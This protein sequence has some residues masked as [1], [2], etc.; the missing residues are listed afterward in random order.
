MRGV[1][2]L[3]RHG[4][5]EP[6]THG[7][8]LGRGDP[9][10]TPRGRSQAAALASSLPRPDRVISSP[11]R[12]AIST[13]DA[14]GRP[15]DVDGRW[16]ELDYGELDGRAASAVPPDVWERWRTDPDFA[17]GGGESLAQLGRRVRSACDDV[18][19]AAADGV[20][21]V[22]THVSPIKAALAWA[23]NAPDTIAWRTFVEDASVSRIDVE[24]A[25]PVLRWF[26]RGVTEPGP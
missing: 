13:A 16:I 3:V 21:I 17:P 6:N 14:F 8:L 20:V 9:P 4:E 11:L 19:G 15:V 22:V 10:L 2:L 5:T 25:G 23:L 7:L 1:L 26:N 18:A 12:R 24:T